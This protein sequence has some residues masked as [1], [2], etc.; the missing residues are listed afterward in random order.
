MKAGVIQ[1]DDAAGHQKWKQ[2]PLQPFEKPCGVGVP[3]VFCRAKQPAA[4]KARYD[5]QLLGSAAALGQT[6]PLASGRAAI[7]SG[8]SSIY[9][10]L[11]YI[12][13]IDIRR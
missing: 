10:A 6:D 8:N 7:L 4:A 13:Y 12:D 9:A 11:I 3:I 2:K 5:I 1:N